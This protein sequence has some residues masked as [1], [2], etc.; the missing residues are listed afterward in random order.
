M[1]NVKS[2]LDA[3]WKL[4]SIFSGGMLG[5]FLLGAF[6]KKKYVKGAIIGMIAGILV[7][8]WLTFSETIFGKDSLGASFHTYL[9]IVFGTIAIFLVGFLLSML[10]K[11]KNQ[12]I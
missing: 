11:P 10:M 6:S 1:I 9:T 8:L 12:T 3:W 5:L 2:A 7:I 4:S